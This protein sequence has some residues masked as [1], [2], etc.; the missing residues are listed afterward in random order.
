MS[1]RHHRA[2]RGL[3]QAALARESGLS[4]AEI[5][6]IETGRVVPSV[7]AALR[8]ARALGAP[9]EALFLPE[10]TRPRWAWQPARW[11]ARVW[12]ADVGS[13]RLAFPCEETLTGLVPHDGIVAEDQVLPDVVPVPTLVLAGCDPAV[14]A[15]ASALA[16]LGVRLLPLTRTSGDAL[17]L[18]GQGLVHAAGVHFGRAGAPVNA[19]AVKKRIGSGYRLLRWAVWEEGVASAPGL[20]ERALE[21]SRL[22][23]LR[24][25]GRA[26]GSGARACIDELFEGHR[27]PRFS[28]MASDHQ[29][30][31]RAIR[32]GVADAGVCVRLPAVAAGLDFQPLRSEAYDFCHSAAL[33]ADSAL[34]A[35]VDRA[36]DAALRRLLSELPGYDASTMGELGHV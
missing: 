36:R 25:V 16:R 19:R 32:L 35:L 3:S 13:Q 4:R 18:L 27:P 9:V 26:P 1:L 22:S 29:E 23:R 12:I 8:L 31:A 20:G 33:E 21:A 14:G 7:H 17:A 5:S 6:A 24:W 2:R 11:P 28:A 30:V 10:A 15:L 34:G